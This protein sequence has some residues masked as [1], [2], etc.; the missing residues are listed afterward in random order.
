ML[1]YQDNFNLTST[2]GA[3]SSYVFSCN[4]LYD[5]NITGTGHQPAGFDQMMLSY[6]HYCV[7]RSRILINFQAATASVYPT[8]AVSQRAASTPNTVAQQNIEDG[9]IITERLHPVNVADSVVSMSMNAN[10]AQFGGLVKILDNTDYRGNIAS[11]PTEQSYFHVQ[12]WSLDANTSTVVC[13]VVIEFEAWFTEPRTLSQSTRSLLKQTILSEMK[14]S[15]GCP[16]KTS[17]KGL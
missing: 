6:E 8:V 10:I 3:V 5:P 7:I 17:T 9:L 12:Q 1:R 14:Q 15:G 13:E 4:G 2:S 16:C 11:N